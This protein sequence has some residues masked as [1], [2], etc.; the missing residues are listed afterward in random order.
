VIGEEG[1]AGT[2]AR[3]FDS[4]ENAEAVRPRLQITYNTIVGVQ[5]SAWTGVKALFR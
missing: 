3:R 2:N 5:P 1:T 4:R